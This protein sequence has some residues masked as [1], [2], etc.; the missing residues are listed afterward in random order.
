M[1]AEIQAVGSLYLD[2][3]DSD[4]M[5]GRP[6]QMSQRLMAQAH[7]GSIWYGF[8]II[9]SDQ[10]LLE[11]GKSARVGIAFL[12]EEGAK[13]AFPI[14]KLIR[15]GDGV[16]TRGSIELQQYVSEEGKTGS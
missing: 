3:R 9:N 15:F 8:V 13:R 12:D 16:R 10:P 5:R 6:L 4:G 2:E 1:D 7:D 11:V 14:S